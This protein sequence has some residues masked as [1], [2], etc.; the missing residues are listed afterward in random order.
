MHL[1]AIATRMSRAR[2]LPPIIRPICHPSKPP[3]P[4]SLIPGIEPSLTVIFYTGLLGFSAKV[5]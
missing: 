4:P 3:F 2:T 5:I 1:K